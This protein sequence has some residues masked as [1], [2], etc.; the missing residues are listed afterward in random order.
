MKILITILLLIFP[1]LVFAETTTT[2]DYRM[3]ISADTK[4]GQFN[5]AVYYTPEEYFS[6]SPEEIQAQAQARVDDWM[7]KMAEPVVA[8][9]EVETEQKLIE[10]KAYIQSKLQ[11]INEKIQELH[12]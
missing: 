2:I 5:D 12:Q 9:A 1:K 6:Y 8:Q 10:D 11:E 3:K 4:Y 7:N